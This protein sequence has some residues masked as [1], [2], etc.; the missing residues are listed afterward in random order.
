MI[1]PGSKL[2]Q[3][4]LLVEGEVPD[5]DVTRCFEQTWGQPL[6]LAVVVDNQ[7]GF[8]HLVESVHRAG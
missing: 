3:A 2:D 5:I 4:L 8:Q 1:S 7:V 6:D